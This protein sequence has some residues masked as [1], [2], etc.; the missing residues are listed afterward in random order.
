M[1]NI[2]LFRNTYKACMGTDNIEKIG[3]QPMK[4]MLKKLGGWPVLE[5]D[6]WDEENFSWIDTVY[7]FRENGYSTDYLI[8]FSI[9]TD[10]KNSSWRVIDIDQASLGMSREYLING[11]DDDDVISYYNYMVNV[12][13]LLGADRVQ[14]ER[15]LKESLKFEIELAEASQ[16]REKRRNATRLYN[17]V[18]IKDLDQ[19]APLVPWLEYINKIL[20]PELLQVNNILQSS[21]SFGK[22]VLYFCGEN[23]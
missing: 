7:K 16:P 8:D 23:R 21:H 13:V 6:S 4:D 11:L 19:V 14:A 3:L 10:S 17:P 2:F 22:N 5:G 20:T 9:V 18:L 15:E 1:L 12:A